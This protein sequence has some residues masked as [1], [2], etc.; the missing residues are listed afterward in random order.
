MHKQ[1]II[2]I[3]KKKYNQFSFLFI[4]EFYIIQFKCQ[5]ELLSAISFITI[6]L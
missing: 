2:Q 3:M 6:P 1:I 4:P 5:K